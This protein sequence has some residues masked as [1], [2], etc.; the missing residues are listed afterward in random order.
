MQ[1]GKR[2]TFNGCRIEVAIE[3]QLL[4]LHNLIKAQSATNISTLGACSGCGE[5][6]KNGEPTITHTPII[7]SPNSISISIDVRHTMGVAVN[8]IENPHRV[9]L[10]IPHEDR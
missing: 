4:M 7:D 8:L 1:V 10:R 6:R 9:W 2:L 5:G 3:R